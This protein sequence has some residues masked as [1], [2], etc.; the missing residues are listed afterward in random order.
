VEVRSAV[1]Y[2]YNLQY[3][4]DHAG[5]AGS[6]WLV[7]A[8]F[9][10][11]RGR[12]MHWRMRARQ[13]ARKLLDRLSLMQVCAWLAGSCCCGGGGG[14]QHGRA[15]YVRRIGLWVRLWGVWLDLCPYR[16]VQW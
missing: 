10:A 1:Q 15:V 2:G 9:R 7:Y 6:R 12:A 11:T 16:W 5:D 13:S 3:G 4:V 14:G 8:H